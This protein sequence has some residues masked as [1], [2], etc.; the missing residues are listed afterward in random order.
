MHSMRLD[1]K[2]VILLVTRDYWVIMDLRILN[3]M[4]FIASWHFFYIRTLLLCCS[5][6]W[7]VIAEW[8]VGVR[9][10]L[11]CVSNSYSL[12]FILSFV[13]DFFTRIKKS[14]NF[15]YFL[16]KNIITYITIHISTNRKINMIIKLINLNWNDKMTLILQWKIFYIITLNIKW[17]EYKNI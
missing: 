7:M 4:G 15:V 5:Y 12:Y 2:N 3:K 8:T 14:F 17:K 13:L 1:S 16:Y 6:I 11:Q 10:K 9:V